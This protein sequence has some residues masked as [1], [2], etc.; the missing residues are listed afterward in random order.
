MDASHS[1]DATVKDD[2]AGLG[3]REIE[4]I[5]SMSQADV[6]RLPFGAIKLDESGTVLGY[7]ATEAHLTGRDPKKVV[8]KNF[9]TEV[10]PCTNVQRFAG[11]YR[12][13]VQEGKLHEKFRYRFDFEMEPVDVLVTLFFDARSRS[14]WVFVRKLG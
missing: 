9:F 13:G 3:L 5:T 6:D 4:A 1:E 2:E 7:N 12:R 11:R 10:A 8:G 14:G